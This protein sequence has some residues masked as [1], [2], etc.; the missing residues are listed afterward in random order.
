VP[1]VADK[2]EFFKNLE[3]GTRQFAV[4]EITPETSH[5]YIFEIGLNKK[6]MNKYQLEEINKISYIQRH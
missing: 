5:V 3:T 4:R 2:K 1:K 6:I